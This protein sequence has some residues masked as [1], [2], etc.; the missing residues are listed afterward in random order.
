MRSC[1]PKKLLKLIVAASVF[2]GSVAS[3]PTIGHAHSLPASPLPDLDHA[4]GLAHSHGSHSHGQPVDEH[5][6]DAV[7]ALDDSVFHLHGVWFGIPFTARAPVEQQSDHS[8][9]VPLADACFTTA[10]P[11]LATGVGPVRE[12]SVCPD[13]LGLALDFNASLQFP[14]NSRLTIPA[15]HEAGTPSALQARSGL[16]R[17]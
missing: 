4:E 3:T 13:A 6:H 17:C 9:R 14:T 16:L 8:R 7:I 15:H 1:G 10:G 2:V 11:G 12:R 5:L